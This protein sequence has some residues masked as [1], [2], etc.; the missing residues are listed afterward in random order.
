MDDLAR[1]GT[2]FQSMAANG[3]E[4]KFALSRIHYVA[5]KQHESI[6]GKFQFVQITVQIKC[7]AGGGPLSPFIGSHRSFKEKY[8]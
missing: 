3:H 6:K 7:G 2:S 5:H 1:H 4:N 8:V